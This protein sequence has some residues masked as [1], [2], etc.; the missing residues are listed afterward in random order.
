MSKIKTTFKN[1]KALITFLTAGDPCK[2][3]TIEYILEMEQ[4]GADI[5]EIG[6]PFSDPTAEG[7]V[8]QA[9]NIRALR[10]GMNTDDIFETIKEVRKKSNIPLVFLTY[11]NPVYHYG[12]ER[13]FNNCGEFGIDGIIIPDLPYEEK[14]EIVPFADKSGVD[15]ISLIAPT[16]EIRIRQIAKEASGFIY[17]VS[18]LGVTG[19][20]NSIITDIAPI[21]NAIRSV[22]DIPIA[23]GFGINTPEQAKSMAELSD[24]VIIGSAIVRIIEKYG[25]NANQAL[26]DYI[27]EIKKALTV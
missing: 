19:V 2:E 8:I 6:I 16:S 17:L 20:R 4:A 23:I 5:I 15:V 26:F 7:P 27:S 13:F 22:T 1:K 18:S 14:D 3:K 11:L 24:G 10:N 25:N 9:A 21:V 12:Y